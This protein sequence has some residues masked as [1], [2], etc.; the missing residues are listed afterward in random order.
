MVS[1]QAARLFKIL[2]LWNRAK[3]SI[4]THTQPCFSK[5]PG[6]RPRCP[7]DKNIAGMNSC[8]CQRFVHPCASLLLFQHS[9]QHSVSEYHRRYPPVPSRR[10]IHPCTVCKYQIKQ[11]QRIRVGSCTT[12]SNN[13]FYL[14]K[15]IQLIGIDSNTCHSHTASHDRDFLS[16]IGTGIS[17]HIADRVKLYRIFQIGFCNEFGA[18]RIP[19]MSTVLA[20]SPLAAALCGVDINTSSFT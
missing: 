14:I 19:G 7:H 11:L 5:I 2:A 13:V 16:L 10:W 8:L 18:E 20:M 1:R 3:L 15:F 6:V 9:A 12:D 4:S 17:E